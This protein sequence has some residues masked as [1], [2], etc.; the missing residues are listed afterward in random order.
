MN[1]NTSR[2]KYID[3]AAILSD[4]TESKVKRRG[5]GLSSMMTTGASTPHMYDTSEL[6]ATNH[7]DMKKMTESY[8]KTAM[9]NE[10]SLKFK[11]DEPIP[12]DLE[13]I[14]MSRDK[15]QRSTRKKR[16]TR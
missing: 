13:A 5:S 7:P 8:Q 12:A 10:P 6:K 4:A 14:E 11:K 16:G 9:K 3:P 2:K 1:K 15:R